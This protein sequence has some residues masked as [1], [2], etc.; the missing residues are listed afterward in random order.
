MRYF[1]GGKANLNVGDAIVPAPPHIDDGCPVCEARAEGRP[2]TVLQYR[3]WALRLIDEGERERGE[4][5]LKAV[6]GAPPDELVDP[7]TKEAAVYVTA[8]LD[9]ANWYA[10]RSRGDLYRVAPVGPLIPSKEDHFHTWTCGEAR[11]VEVLR[12]GVMLDRRDRR[13]LERRWKRADAQ[14]A[15][16]RP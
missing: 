4:R 1:H 12:R 3:A 7:P 15:R 11:V 2:F 9:Y 16:V 13:L 6:L 14:A 8:D 10:A 5:M